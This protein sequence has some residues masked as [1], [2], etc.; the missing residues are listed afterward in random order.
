VDEL[1]LVACVEADLVA[2]VATLHEATGSEVHRDGTTVWVRS[3]ELDPSENGV[4]KAG[5]AAD[6]PSED[7]Q[8]GSSLS[9]LLE[10]FRS[11]SLPMTWWWFTPIGGLDPAIDTGMARL[12]LTRVG[13][14][15]A[16]ALELAGFR[17]QDP[18]D[19][20][21]VT[22]VLDE[23]ALMEWSRVV[24]VAFDD[25]EQ[26]EG[27]S[28]R[29]TLALGFGDDAPFRHFLGSI[30]GVAV[31]A[32]TLSLAGGVAGFANVSTLPSHRGR[33]IGGAMVGAAI[34]DAR[35][36]GQTV[37]ALSAED[38]G[39]GVYA[40]LGFRTVGRHVIYQWLPPTP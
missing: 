16:M 2:H 25:P 40:R 24:G 36:S 33:G 37:G 18:P 6:R 1:E 29:G 3:G 26:S 34:V 20:L 19:G 27:R 7:P 12:G 14:R 38:L 32:C 35:D 23:G 17:D 5:I 31:A 22:R 39:A 13:N 30:E 9:R 10:P 28:V 11:R 15:P 4:L 8:L 21:V